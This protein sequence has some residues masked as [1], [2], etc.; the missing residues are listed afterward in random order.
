MDVRLLFLFLRSESSTEVAARPYSASFVGALR[1][2]R[3]ALL[4]EW[5]R[6]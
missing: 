3:A 1:Q 5:P 2:E 4:I 6:N